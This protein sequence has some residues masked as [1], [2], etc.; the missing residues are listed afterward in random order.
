MGNDINTHTAVA[1]RSQYSSQ[2][3]LYNDKLT[4][5]KYVYGNYSALIAPR[6][7]CAAEETCHPHL[8]G[9]ISIFGRCLEPLSVLCCVSAD[10][11]ATAVCQ[12]RNDNQ[13]RQYRTESQ[14][15]RCL[16]RRRK[17]WFLYQISLIEYLLL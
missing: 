15:R 9:N 12:L 17:H 14:V 2:Q 10:R 4:H 7:A 11:V 5:L 13:R 1:S 16:V 3:P 6:H 8:I